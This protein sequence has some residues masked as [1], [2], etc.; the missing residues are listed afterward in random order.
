MHR[1]LYPNLFKPLKIKGLTLKNR[2]MSA[3]NMLFQTIAGRP[4]EYYIRYLEHKARGGA[5]I[6]TLGEV[7]VCDG[8]RHTPGMDFT[9]ENLILFA[10]MSAAIREHGAVSSVELTHGGRNAR[11]EFNTVKSMGPDETE[12]PYG[13]VSAMTRQDMENVADAFAEAAAFWIG[14]GFDT[15][16]VHAAHG[17]LFP[18]FLSPLSNHRTD[19]FGGSLENRMRFPLMVLRRIREKVGPDRVVQIRLSGSERDPGLYRGGYHRIPFKGPGI[20]RYGGNKLR[21]LVWFFGSTYRPWG[22]NTDLSEAIKKSGRV[23]IPIFVIG[24]ILDP[25]LAEDII[26]SGKADGVSM[27]RA[28]IADPYLPEKALTGRSD[29]ITPCLRCLNCTDS[30]NLHRHLVCSVNPLIGR[31]ARLGFAEDMKKARYSRRVL[32]V[33]GGPAGMQAAITASDR[34]HEVI[35]CEKENALGGL[36]RLADGDSLK[37][38]LRRYKNYLTSM[39]SKKNIRVLLNTPVCDGLLNELKPDH[40]IVATGSTPVVPGIRGIDRARHVTDIYFKP[41]SVKGNE[42]VIIGGGL[43]GIEAGLHL[44]NLGKKVT[45]LEMTDTPASDSGPVYRIGLLWKAER[46]GLRVIA[47]ARAEEATERGVFY[48]KDG[49]EMELPA[50]SVFYAAGMKSNDAPFFELAGK[51]VHV[52]MVGDCKAVGKVAGAVHSGYF[53]ALDIGKF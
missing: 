50:S 53:A 40:I 31:E 14:C 36:L 41:E 49:K 23:K 39:V 44:A 47:G 7:P 1:Q 4:T 2:I 10:E 28:L 12:T 35:L 20:C 11:P 17:W 33:G 22:L 29:E 6:V 46:L 16:L 24:S 37:L 42:I 51:A 25:A 38:D 19:E 15:V 3:P 48:F 45:V 8:G 32:V 26:T 27:S 21:K 43:A 18:Q 34:G 52:D 9:R 30:D 13:K 5:G